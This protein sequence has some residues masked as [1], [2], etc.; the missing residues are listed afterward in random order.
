MHLR[1]RLVHAPG[2]VRAL[3]WV[4]PTAVYFGALGLLTGWGTPWWVVS[5]LFVLVAAAWVPVGGEAW[6]RRRLCRK[7]GWTGDVFAAVLV[8]A[9]V[10]DGFVPE[11][12][13]TRRELARRYAAEARRKKR[14]TRVVAVVYGAVT[15]ALVVSFIVSDDGVW[16]AVGV[17]GLAAIFQ[18]QA[19]VR[20]PRHLRV[21]RRLGENDLDWSTITA[22]AGVAG[23]TAV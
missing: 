7:L 16:G 11:E 13:G 2:W 20:L 22:R 8:R 23:K 15:M 19:W 21:F 17:L 1:R 4:V 14:S 18:Y 5:C 10:D 9:D 3:V 12:D 6:E